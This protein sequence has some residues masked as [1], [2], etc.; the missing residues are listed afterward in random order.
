[1]ASVDPDIFFP[2]DPYSHAQRKQAQAICADCP[3]QV[4][5]LEYAVTFPTVLYGIWAGTT[6][7]QRRNIRS[8]RLQQQLK[9][10]AVNE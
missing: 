7:R 8:R 6:E 4:E 3:V 10:E 9:G 1:M 2:P 5:C